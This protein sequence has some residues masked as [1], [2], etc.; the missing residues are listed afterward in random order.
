MAFDDEETNSDWERLSL[1]QDESLAE[2]DNNTTRPLISTK[3]T[4]FHDSY[5]LAMKAAGLGLASSKSRSLDF[6]PVDSSLF[7]S[8]R[9]LKL[10]FLLSAIAALLA[11]AWSQSASPPASN[12]PTPRPMVQRVFAPSGAIPVQHPYQE[13][14]QGLLPVK[15]SAPKKIL[16]SM[17]SPKPN[18]PP[19]AT[20]KRAL[21]SETKKPMT[22]VK[23][24]KEKVLGIVPVGRPAPKKVLRL[25]S[26]PAVKSPSALP[27]QA[28]APKVA[29]KS[30]PRSMQKKDSSLVP[31]SPQSKLSSMVLKDK[32]KEHPRQTTT[33]EA[34]LD[35]QKY[36]TSLLDWT[37][38]TAKPEAEVAM[39]MMKFEPLR[40][41]KNGLKDVRKVLVK[42]VTFVRRRL[43]RKQ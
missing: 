22:M 19:R 15:R 33:P 35:L 13:K 23:P 34:E 36:L 43:R 12:L 38:P 9:Y 1:I 25:G 32:A 30:P 11:A 3:E 21:S 26:Q 2:N 16:R 17:G 10:A 29:P 8:R 24:F 42:I 40:P 18:T 37:G 4:M 7:G 27:E 20:V 14:F 41:L 6:P 28:I 39:P 5:P 31:S